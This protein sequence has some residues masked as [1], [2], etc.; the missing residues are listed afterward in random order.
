MSV[1]SVTRLDLPRAELVLLP[2]APAVQP[3]H[4]L[5]VEFRSPEGRSWKAIGGGDTLAAA[6]EWA[7]ESCPRGATWQP[8]G[9]EDLYGD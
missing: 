6:I 7:R 8:V 1:P 5:T 4:I 3:Q 2:V 9:W